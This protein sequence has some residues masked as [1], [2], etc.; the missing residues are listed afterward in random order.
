MDKVTLD[1]GFG[2]NVMLKKVLQ[3]LGL[4]PA[5]APF[6]LQMANQAIAE[7]CGMVEDVLTQ[8]SGIKFLRSFLVLK[9]GEA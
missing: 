1:G 7:P 9:V 5:P 3:N 8:I 2:I 6:Q 4:T